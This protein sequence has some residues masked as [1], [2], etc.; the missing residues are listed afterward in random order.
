V[1]TLG[2]V[3]RNPLDIETWVV[4][5][6]SFCQAGKTHAAYSF[7][8]FAL[9]L[10]TFGSPGTSDAGNEH[11]ASNARATPPI[12]IRMLLPQIRKKKM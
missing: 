11:P 10:L 4:F 8:V 2:A 1:I 9:C 5:A 6:T 7:G 3:M 12:N